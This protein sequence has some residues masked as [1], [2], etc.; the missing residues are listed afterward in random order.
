MRANLP[1]KLAH[2]PYTLVVCIALYAASFLMYR[3]D[4]AAGSDGGILWQWLD[5]SF[6]ALTGSRW[7]TLALHLLALYMLLELDTVFALIRQRTLF[8]L[9]SMLLLLSAL[10]AVFN[11]SAATIGGMLAFY[12]L[13]PFFFAYQG[14][15]NALR[16]MQSGIALGLA[17]M[18]CPHALLLAVLFVLAMP[19][20]RN[21]SARN[22]FGL[23]WGL[24]MPYFFL[25][26]Y[27]YCTDRMQLVHE[28]IGSVVYFGEIDYN[29]LDLGTVL[30]WL[31]M[32]VIAA[33]SV[34]HV[35][36]TGYNDKIK[37]RFL[38]YFLCWLT[39]CIILAATVLPSDAADLMSLATMPT[40]LLIAHTVTLLD[41]RGGTVYVIVMAAAMA[42]VFTINYVI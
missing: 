21:L 20:L 16:M 6:P 12:A 37:T 35:T 38:L 36:Y 29:T 28:A 25:A 41:T 26:T 27:A 18:F 39:A 9:S 24:A 42:G 4:V 34:T 10:P 3:H 17:S 8:Q 22:I 40:A 30:D 7:S 31:L 33:T 13:F 1:A 14:N 15:N 23:L 32:M 5:E 2:N 11:V 19:S